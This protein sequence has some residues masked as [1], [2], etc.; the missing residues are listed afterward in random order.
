[1]NQYTKKELVELLTMPADAFA[2]DITPAAKQVHITQ[3]GNR[4][5]AT[6][7][8]GYTNIC[9]NQCLYCGMRAANH[10]LPRYRLTPGEITALADAATES[11][12][13]RIFL[14]AGE[15]PN[16]G[17]DRLV[18]MVAAL[19]AK[20]FYISLACGE[21]GLAEFRALHD[22]GADEYVLKFE[23]SDRDD[24]NRLN[25]STDYDRRLQGCALVKQAGMQLASGNIVDYP[26]ATPEK[27]ANDILL[28]RE[29]G[30]SWAP[31]ISY[32]PTQNTPLA[33]EGGPGSRDL[34]RREISILR[35][36]MPKVNISAQ[37]PG[38]DLTQGLGGE[39]GNLAALAAGG[40]FLFADLL[41]AAKAEAFH[42]VDHRAVQGLAHI[43]KMARLAGMALAF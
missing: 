31:V 21:F 9:K 36:M 19:K 30:I 13:R 7:M 29:L 22:A 43:E 4:L 39:E 18:Q 12:L 6:A 23:M 16:Y 3:N 38:D 1:M 15:D 24:F 26:G 11:G 27:I 8:L 20:G 28:M 14:I 33:A 41:P 5:T 17:F 42:V 25:P 2:A 35:L 32:L 34:L 10:T 37:Q 40:N